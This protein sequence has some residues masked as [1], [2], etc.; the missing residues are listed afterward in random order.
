VPAVVAL[1]K[2]I[3]IRPRVKFSRKNIYLR[4]DFTCQYCGKKFTDVSKL[5]FDHVTPKCRGGKTVW[6]NIVASCF[7]CN[8][9]KKGCLTVEQAGMKL[10]KI[11]EQPKFLGSWAVPLSIPHTPEQWKSYLYWNTDISQT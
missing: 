4:D 2:Y 7:T 8:N 9:R 5:T 11:P 6:E 1:K 3:N 10:I